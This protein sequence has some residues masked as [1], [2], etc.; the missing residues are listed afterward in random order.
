[1]KCYTCLL[2][3]HTPYSFSKGL[4]LHPLRRTLIIRQQTMYI[5]PNSTVTKFNFGKLSF[6]VWNK[7]ATVVKAVKEFESRGMLSFKPSTIPTT[8][9]WRLSIFAKFQLTSYHQTLQIRPRFAK[10]NASRMNIS[11]VQLLLVCI[12]ILYTKL[13]KKI[14]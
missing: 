4:H 14:L 10:S 2:P 11:K 6:E 3:R 8:D 5:Y 1:L 7:E 13:P 12:R 9:F